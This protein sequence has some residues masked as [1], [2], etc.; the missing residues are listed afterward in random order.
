MAGEIVKEIFKDANE[1]VKYPYK[2]LESI[3]SK[4]IV[5]IGYGVYG[6]VY[7]ISKSRCLKI[8]NRKHDY[9]FKKNIIMDKDFFRIDI[10]REI[11][12]NKII[13]HNYIMT[14]DKIHYNDNLG[15]Y[16]EG[17]KA[18]YD[19]KN[20]ILNYLLSLDQFYSILKRMVIALKYLH[21]KGFIHSDIK[22]SNILVKD[23]N[24]FLC[25]L[26]ILQ[27]YDKNNDENKDSLAVELYSIPA[28]KRSFGLDIHMLGGTL[29]ASLIYKKIGK[30]VNYDIHTLQ[31]YKHIIIEIYGNNQKS[32]LTIEILKLMMKTK[33]EHRINLDD[34]EY[35]TNLMIG[36][37]R[38]S[39]N[40]ATLFINKLKNDRFI[41]DSK[42]DIIIKEVETISKVRRIETKTE[43]LIADI[44][45]K[46]SEFYDIKKLHSEYIAKLFIIYPDY[47]G[48]NE[49][50]DITNY[51]EF[52]ND[53][54]KIFEDDRDFTLSFLK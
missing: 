48:D 51:E 8:F 1:E 43:K 40:K 53:I 6:S 24:F 9:C 25:D 52:N 39:F 50:L 37:N 14:F 28:E 21:S 26:S 29:L 15:H 38:Q 35:L 42:S 19:L 3:Y 45:E 16:L 31:K 32:K 13:K 34:L 11:M 27:Y 36:N 41:G 49:I 54:I 12:F 44:G 18:Y 2:I 30:R 10:F 17:D 4:N 7:E 23:G 5:L 33:L 22:P 46:I 47:Y 20:Y